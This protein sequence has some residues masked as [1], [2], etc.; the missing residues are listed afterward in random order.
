MTGK[1]EF[2]K[3]GTH[4]ARS[5]QSAV[6]YGHCDGKCEVAYK[7]NIFHK[8]WDIARVIRQGAREDSVI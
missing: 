2:K 7:I 3:K 8:S 1:D 5:V 4:A 6:K